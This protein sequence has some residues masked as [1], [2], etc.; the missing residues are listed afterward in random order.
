MN[1]TRRSILSRTLQGLRRAWRR[2]QR[3]SEQG[4]SFRLEA[5]EPRLALTISAPLPSATDHIH[6]VL[7]IM[8][9]GEQV[10]I[11]PNIGLT[12]T[13]HFN[14][15]THDF[16]GTLHIGEGGPAG[17]GST[18]RNVTLQD[19]FDVWRTSNVGQVTNNPNA[20]FD[21]DPDD[22][23]S[24]PRILNKTVDAGHVLRM[25]VKE[26][27]DAV[28]ELEYDSSS[29]TNSLERPELYVPR[30]GDQVTI[31]YD[32]IATAADSPSF[33]PI[34]NQTLLVGAPLWLA[35]DG[36]DPNGGPLTYSV[37]VGNTSL[38]QASVPTGNRSVAIDVASVG[39]MK[40]QL[41]DNLVPDVTNRIAQLINAGFYNKTASNQITFHRVINNFMIQAGDPTGTGSGGSTLP[42]FDDKFHLD[43]QHTTSGLLSMAKSG[44]D[45]NDSQFF[46]TDVPTRHLDFNHSIFGRLTE[47]DV[48][49]DTINSVP[50][51]DDDKPLSPVVINSI[52]FINDTENGVLMLK[53][54]PGATGSTSVTVTVTDAQNHSFSRTF[55]VN[56]TPD[57]SNSAPFL[58]PI[59]E[60]VR[61]VVGQSIQLQLAAVDAEGNPNFFDAVRPTSETVN[62]TVTP[63]NNTGLVV[64]TPPAGF[65]G[66]FNVLVGVS[67]ATQTNTSDPFDTQLVE[68]DVA[69][70][71]PTVDLLAASDSG[72]SNSD[73]ITNAGT[74]QFQI[75]GVTNG[76]LVKLLK[77][78]TVL[79][80]GT[81]SGTSIALST[82][83]IA[84]A[85]EGVHG[86]TATQTVSGIESNA[87]ALLN[88]TYDITPPPAFTSTPPTEGDVGIALQY[89][90]QNPEESSAGFRYELV[91]Q[92][93]GATIDNTTGV[94][95]WTPLAAQIGPQTFGILASD[96][97]GNVRTQS[98][99]VVV[100][101]PLPPKVDLV[102]ELTQPNGS[103][104][105]SLNS[106][107]SF[108]LKVSTRD[109][110]TPSRGVF[111]A[112]MDILWD[113]TKAT[114]NGNITYGSEYGTQPS[115]TASPGLIDEVGAVAGN[116]ELGGGLHHLF[117]IP[118]VAGAAGSLIFVAD[119]ADSLPAHDALVYGENAAV[120]D[121]V[122]F[123]SVSI[124]I[125]AS[126]NAVND[127]FNVNEDA[128]NA[129]LNPLL[130]DTNIGNNQNV[131][132]I[133]AVGSTSSGGTV[134][135]APD[136]KSLKYSPAA[137]F[138][139]AETFTYTARNQN[140]E[141]NVATI[142]VQVQ[143]SND[144]PSGVNDSFNVPEDSQ[145]FVLDVLGNDLTSPDTGETL[146]VTQ[147][148][149]G[150][151]G[152][153][154][155]IGNNGANIRYT[156]AL[157]FL[158]TE[159]FT[160]TL[161][162]RTTG[163]LTSTASVT[164]TVGEV[165]D[166]PVATSDSATV[167]EDSNETTINVVANDGI[168]PDTGETISV[169]AVA[170]ASAGGTIS[171]ADGGQAVIYKP[172]ADFQ[173]T[174]T[175]TYTLT[176]SRGG[177]ATGVVT[178]TVSNSN[179][180]PTAVNDNLTGFKD[181]TSTFD[182]LANDSSAPDPT[183]NLV[184]DSITQPQHGTLTIIDGG[185]KVSYTP[186]A[187]YTGPDSF[188][189]VVRDPG[190]LLTEPATANIT[191]QE[192]AP[193]T[194]SGFVYFDVDNDGQH[195]AAELP[196]SGVTITLTGTT[197]NSQSVNVTV[198]TLHDGSY[199]FENLAPGNY[200]LKQ[201]QPSFTIDGQDTAG[202]QG[203]T[204]TNDQI[205]IANLAQ[206]TEGENN[207]FGE[208]GRALSTISI[209]DL[210]S[211]NSRDYAI[212]AL[213]S[214]GQELWHSTSGPDWG[215]YT[216]TAFSLPS[217]AQLR[218]QATNSL[219]Q[220]V[221]AT[222]NTTSD[223][224]GLIGENSGSKL[225]RVRGGPD[226]LSFIPFA[227]QAPVGVGDSYN[228]TEETVLTVP[229]AGV[230]SNDTDAEGN[231]L[232]ASIVTLPTKGSLSFNANGSF[233]YTPNVN[234][235]GADSFTYRAS[236]GTNQ[237]APVTA[238]ISI[239]GVNDAPLAAAD[240]Y[241]ANAG[242]PLVVAAADGVIDNDTDVDQQT[243]TATVLT[244][245]SG[246][247]VTLAANGGFTFTA[248]AG[249]SGLTTFTYRV[250][251][252]TLT[253][254][255]TVSL[256][257]N[258]PPT[259]ANDDYAVDEDEALTVAVADGVLD[260]D[261][262]PDGNPLTA[263]VVSQ[264]QHGTLTLAANGSFVYT[265]DDDFEG[266][267]GFSYKAND[268]HADSTVAAVTITVNPV[269]DAPV[270]AANSFTTP[271]NT[272]LTIDAPGVLAG[273]TDV[274]EDT[275]TATVITDPDHGTLDL[276]SDGSFTY[277][278]DEGYFGPDS[279]VYRASDG[280][281]H[282]QATV[283]ITVEEPGEGGQGGEG[284][285]A[286]ELALL[287]W[288]SDH[289]DDGH[290]HDHGGDWQSA[291]DEAFGEL[292]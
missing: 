166:P 236:D 109:L 59:A 146:R 185:K 262:D 27:G 71:A 266:T 143:P 92:P 65:V 222:L 128:V 235:T 2:R 208:R 247:A 83:D 126:F 97:A 198:K 103:P 151:A 60:P 6:P 280:T 141:T 81:A 121:K 96:A 23:T 16:T 230:L 197:I 123:G 212:A 210:F 237:S 189:Y 169:T 223:M 49:R 229:S 216:N 239:A 232:T 105:T 30:D 67:G 292:G 276:E 257:V 104:L 291:V 288:L 134:T 194:L 283:S 115:G 221:A 85:G 88:V 129:T 172:A 29:A 206:G 78:T 191:V 272:Q 75:S 76:A 117:S 240:A 248:T 225:F 24:A 144:P 160:Y 114:V 124:S 118:M 250:T 282:S 180:P 209:A 284:E 195:D 205:V 184:I 41:F 31:S 37:Q 175:F 178:V 219:A 58:Q 84:A 286:G 112:Y 87:S 26:P 82:T 107:Q 53:A 260:N 46:I 45:T 200:T 55:Q 193:S 147:V 93:A 170:S 279:F 273:D 192:F 4:R 54:A 28:A 120:N 22:G 199:A 19:F 138:S 251:D 183:E 116:N 35:L 227:N 98:V 77:G 132:T 33:A 80:Q 148:S 119:P 9:E 50:V 136:G 271:Q 234:A 218:V 18:V 269:N 177:T 21:T 1:K 52:S 263:I 285:S 264:P 201:T 187:G 8:I 246:G 214:T 162:D 61:G 47:G 14:P 207:N 43:L 242:T 173:G 86:I 5:L 150:S 289:E 217:T 287:S 274:D 36:F 113:S 130:N 99:S 249:F 202:S 163:G 203:G 57:T 159:T 39:T 275:L 102:L 34:A 265:P 186:T 256:T 252:G 66:K 213:D 32:A 106:G 167:A 174:E 110:R 13:T 73:N 181:T 156:P 270:A 70:A 56:L 154:L 48:L 149:A 108:I 215:D 111:S 188:T 20:I 243:L 278:P 226:N 94:L 231:P 145:N 90:A 244:Q 91:T 277:T 228:A 165:N 196:L 211:S 44:D 168:G 51:D 64:I 204:V 142:T 224:L 131:L 233:I 140:N 74:L 290:S 125:N 179:D 171:V 254:D 155:T 220:V 40:F 153:T 42:D 89:N 122:R 164:L 152:G 258:R 253:S 158:G 38:L 95:N 11:G 190:G 3:R 135:I 7:K 72:V 261:S 245:P 259:A 63:N 68:V 176:D 79:A 12:Q 62:Y 15:H 10:T 139:G 238:T 137:N 100:S 157:N 182:V 267:D 127:T 268:G 25:Y 69:P 255:A 281:L 241:T 133:S 17:I 101:Q 161:S